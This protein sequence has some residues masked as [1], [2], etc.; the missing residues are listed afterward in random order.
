[1]KL[2]LGTISVEARDAALSALSTMIAQSF[3]L[4]A[5][6]SVHFRAAARFADRYSYGLRAGDALH[7]AIAGESSATVYTLDKR[8]ARAGQELGIASALI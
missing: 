8:L 5:V 7:L 2:R 3:S 6:S 4:L 1:M